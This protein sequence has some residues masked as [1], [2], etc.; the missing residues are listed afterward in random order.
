MT[1]SNLSVNIFL[2]LTKVLVSY[3]YISYFHLLFPRFVAAYPSLFFTGV[4]FSIPFLFPIHGTCVP[5]TRIWNR[6][7]TTPKE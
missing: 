2:F 6:K 3:D 4:G 5:G 1:S 7:T